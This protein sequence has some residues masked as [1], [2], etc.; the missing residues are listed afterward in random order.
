MVNEEFEQLLG[1]KVLAWVGAVA[2]VA[3]FALLFA[4]GIS[5]GWIGEGERTLMAAGVS[6]MLLLSGVWLHER[7]GQVQAARAAAATGI[8]GLFMVATVASAVYD[9]VPAMAGLGIAFAIGALATVLALRW[10]S[11]LMGA[12]GVAGAVIAPVLVGAPSTTTT[13][14]F[15]A[16]AVAS[17]VGVLLWARWDWLLLTVIGLSAP[18]W[19]VWLFH[20]HSAV[21][22]V[23]LSIV[24]GALY[25]G[26]ALGFEL[27]V[28]SRRLR[29]APMGVT[30]LNALMLGVAGWMRLKGLGHESL[31]LFWLAFLSCAHLAGGL[32][33]H[34]SR[35]I[36]SDLGLVCLSLAVLLADVAFALTVSGPGRAVGFAAGGVVMAL[37]AR[38][39]RGADGVLAQYGLGGHI[40]VSALQALHDVSM[41]T[42][43]DG[44]TAAAVGALVAVAVGCLLSG[45]LAEEGHETWRIALDTTGLAALAGIALMTLDGASLAIAWSAQA[46]ALAKIGNRRDDLLAQAASVVHLIA[47]GTYALVFL[48]P[49]SGLVEGV[50]DIGAAALGGG[51]VAAATALCALATSRAEPARRVLAL[52]TPIVALYAASVVL[53]S[54]GPDAQGQLMVSALWALS[55]VVALVVGLRRRDRTVRMGA[56]N[57]LTLAA[58]KVFLYDLA[59]LDSIYRVGSF[60]ALGLLLLAGALAYQRMR[61]ALTA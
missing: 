32:A 14:V 10:S 58:G 44:S 28:P 43:S 12:L 42:A 39:H 54:L 19:L 20:T 22:V 59:A 23:A 4:M 27:R 2:V 8:C 52:A 33:A 6:L 35:R 1:G 29:L 60:L 15:E 51:A 30:A 18:Q 36:T 50:S 61:P 55:G 56:W 31:A 57:L 37:L 53:V 13:I 48:V 49:P 24:F 46:A 5:R 26:A 3:G 16:V 25:A 45:R 47:A 41:A 7:R 21:A 38:K 9:L 17:A 11:P 34:R 40:A